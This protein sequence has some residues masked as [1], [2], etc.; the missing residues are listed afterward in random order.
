MFYNTPGTVLIAVNIKA[1]LSFANLV[2]SVL[3]CKKE[4]PGSGRWNHLLQISPAFA[5]ENSHISRSPWLGA[6]PGLYHQHTVKRCILT[7]MDPPWSQNSVSTT[8][9]SF[10][11]F[12]SL[13]LGQ[14][15]TS[16]SLISRSPRR[17]KNYALLSGSTLQARLREMAHRP[18][19]LGFLL[20]LEDHGDAFLKSQFLRHCSS[21]ATLQNI[22]LLTPP[23]KTNSLF[24]GS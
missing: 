15:L 18:G 7:L 24:C 4:E 3:S 5:R 6:F 21:L 19:T 16:R 2:P 1:T 14:P 13:P 22:H 17:H 20:L 23:D 11:F 12:G 10:I 8:N 9:S